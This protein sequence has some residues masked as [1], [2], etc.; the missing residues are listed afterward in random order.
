VSDVYTLA[1]R[2]VE[3]TST[4]FIGSIQFFDLTWLNNK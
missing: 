4:D 3:G 2:V 1:A